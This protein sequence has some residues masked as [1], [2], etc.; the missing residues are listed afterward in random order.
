MAKKIVRTVP[1]ANA[2]TKTKLKQNRYD[3]QIIPAVLSRN[4]NYV[5]ILATRLRS[6]LKKHL[7]LYKNEDNRIHHNIKVYAP[8]SFYNFATYK[9]KRKLSYEIIRNGTIHAANNW[10]AFF[11]KFKDT[12]F[13]TDEDNNWVLSSASYQQKLYSRIPNENTE[14][15][16]KTVHKK[17]IFLGAFRQHY[18]HFI[19]Q[20]LSR[21]WFL[22]KNKYNDYDLIYI[23]QGKLP[24]FVFKYLELFGIDSN[25]LVAI[26]ETTKYDEIIVPEISFALDTFWTDEFKKTIDRIQKHITPVK[27]KNIYLSRMHFNDNCIGEKYIEQIYKENGYKIIYPE[28]MSIEEQISVISGAKNIVGVVGTALHNLMFMSNGASCT[29][30]ERYNRPNYNQ[31]IIND[32]RSLKTNYVYANDSFL[33][34]ASGKGPYLLLN[35]EYLQKYLD[36]NTFNYKEQDTALQTALKQTYAVAWYLMYHEDEAYMR[37]LQSYKKMQ[38]SID[39]H[40]KEFKKLYKET[41]IT[42]VSDKELSVFSEYIISHQGNDEILINTNKII[43]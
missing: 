11:Q 9:L 24:N 28:E 25:R 15:N 14:K 40:M 17:A 5:K 32:M 27:N 37:L 8:N 31:I 4:N 6:I 35:T 7:L 42:M 1:K 10:G 26:T 30:L 23:P 36:D 22:L 21:L 19:C 20:G 39:N 12:G 34:C 16:I 3:S 18:G 33:P 38:T 41:E 29:I 43:K 2:N 13:I